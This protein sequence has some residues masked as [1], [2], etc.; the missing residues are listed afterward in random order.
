[1]SKPSRVGQPHPIR[2]ALPSRTSSP[3]NG[4]VPVSTT[5]PSDRTIRYERR[6]LEA[7]LRRAQT[8]PLITATM[9]TTTVERPFTS[10]QQR[11]MRHSVEPANPP[12]VGNTTGTR[13]SAPGGNPG[14]PDD[15]RGQTPNPP[16]DNGNH[17]GG[18]PNPGSPGGPGDPGDPGGNPP[19]DNPPSDHDSAADDQEISN[20]ELRE[21]ILALARG[22]RRNDE[23]KKTPFKPKEPDTFDGSSP[24]DL[25]T[26]IFQC[27]VY[28]N[29]CKSEFSKDAHRVY[30]AISYLR[31]AALDYFEPCINEPDPT[32][33]YD[34]LGDWNAFVQRLV[35]LFG[36]YS[37]E[38]DDEDAITSLSFPDGGKA[39]KYFIEFAKYQ[40]RIKW[41]DRSLRKIVKDAIPARIT[42]EL[43]FIH[44]D[45]S[46]FEGFKR[47]VLKID[48]DYWK[49]K[50]DE[51]NKQRLVQ[52]LQSRLS[53][54]GPKPNSKPNS[55]PPKDQTSS[56]SSSNNNNSSNPGK[57]QNSKQK[58][59][60]PSNPSSSPTN[61]PQNQPRNDRLGPDGKLTAAERQRRYDN[62]LCLVC[63]EKGHMAKDCPRSKNKS[64]GSTPNT[65]ARAAKTE[66][67]AGPSQPKN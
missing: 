48:N 4:S 3:S 36:S 12:P 59:K 30:F 66:A 14:D 17:P 61:P 34:F 41:D 38:D 50:Q 32:E 19:D 27:Q 7:E 54:S 35:N 65:K 18:P 60:Q 25:R 24:Q 21:A 15:P 16:S 37:P 11:Q 8:E 13:P 22:S 26:F 64:S 57:K 67:E 52:S 55:S 63:G 53:K 29:A 9:S 62:G 44:E 45:T 56:A 6:A 47:A 39:T 28:F 46:T 33:P 10:Q 43:R 40:T 51:A 49:R 31:G 1:M 2:T 23:P 42:N 58:G 5:T 20:R